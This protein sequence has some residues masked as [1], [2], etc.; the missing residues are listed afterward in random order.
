MK[1]FE[2]SSGLR[3]VFETISKWR[4]CLDANKFGIVKFFKL[5]EHE[6]RGTHNNSGFCELLVIG[7]SWAT[8]TGLVN[9][10]SYLKSKLERIIGLHRKNSG[11]LNIKRTLKLSFSGRSL[12]GWPTMSGSRRK[13][14]FFPFGFEYM[15]DIGIVIYSWL[16]KGHS[17]KSR[18]FIKVFPV[19]RRQ[20]WK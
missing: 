16:A 12:T 5:I 4:K 6:L 10:V 19:F 15:S 7:R 2:K 1:E 18:R 11:T 13:I 17:V 14:N 8:S 3:N 20:C 9:Y